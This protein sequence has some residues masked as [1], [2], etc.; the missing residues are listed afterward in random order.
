M[1]VSEQT[2]VI[3]L[4]Q[5]QTVVSVVRGNKVIYQALIIRP[6]TTY[7]SHTAVFHY[8]LERVWVAQISHHQ[9]GVGHTKGTEMGERSLFAMTR[10]ATILLLLLLHKQNNNFKPIHKHVT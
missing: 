8:K 9:V 7:R 3:S 6:N 4:Y 2:A 1:W 10:I 5:E